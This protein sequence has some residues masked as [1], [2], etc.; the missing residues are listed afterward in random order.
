MPK[1][2]ET[3]GQFRERRRRQEAQARARARREDVESEDEETAGSS[4]VTRPRIMQPRKSTLPNIYQ[5]SDTRLSA[6][7]NR[8]EAKQAENLPGEYLRHLEAALPFIQSFVLDVTYDEL[9][10]EAKDSQAPEKYEALMRLMEG[11]EYPLQAASGLYYTKDNVLVLVFLGD[12]S[13]SMKVQGHDEGHLPLEAQFAEERLASTLE[14]QAMEF[15]EEK[16]AQLA[17]RDAERQK[18]GGKGFKRKRFRFESTRPRIFHD[19]PLLSLI[20]RYYA[21]VHTMCTYNPPPPDSTLKRHGV[22]DGHYHRFPLLEGVEFTEVETEKQTRRMVFSEDGGQTGLEPAGVHH[23]VEGWKMQGHSNGSLYLSKSLSG[24]GKSQGPTR[25]F[26][27]ANQTLDN[28]I[29]AAMEVFFP[30]NYIVARKVREAGRII[31][32]EGGVYLGR[33]VVFKLQLLLH[34]DQND[35]GVSTSF[36][37]GYYCGGYLIIP[38]LKAK[39]RYAHGDMAMFKASLLLHKITEWKAHSMSKDDAIT[40]GRVGTVLFNPAASVEYLEGKEWGFA[41]DTVYGKLPSSAP[42]GTRPTKER[43]DLR[44][45]TK[46]EAL[47]EL[48]AKKRRAPRLVSKTPLETKP[49]ALKTRKT[50]NT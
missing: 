30:D 48:T 38:Q 42:G 9:V 24:S 20:R 37:S 1:P 17:A 16:R 44:T 31:P 15:E 11:E 13:S 21:S 34:R 10:A 36:P 3:V 29:A 43:M 47:D 19:G 5:T 14:K 6:N 45:V 35:F 8:S 33:A 32:G 23:C 40:P 46:R 12:R 49:K 7:E 27:A 28:C 39:F 22:S 2:G 41:S 50:R 26:Y 18:V 25:H 4:R